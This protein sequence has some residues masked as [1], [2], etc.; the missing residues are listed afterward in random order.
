MVG[1]QCKDANIGRQGQAPADT[2]V[3]KST[4]GELLCSVWAAVL[5]TVL[6]MGILSC[7]RSRSVIW[8]AGLLSSGWQAPEQLLQAVNAMLPFEELHIYE[9]HYQAGQGQMPVLAGFGSVRGLLQSIRKMLH[10]WPEASEL[11]LASSIWP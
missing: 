8:D 5:V 2:Q 1:Y 10:L 11:G 4:R 9:L 7:S 3:H 6:I